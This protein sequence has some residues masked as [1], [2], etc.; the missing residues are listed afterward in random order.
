ML[1][2]SSSFSTVTKIA[3]NLLN[4]LV[5]NCLASSARLFCPGSAEFHIL[6][7]SQKSP[8]SENGEGLGIHLDDFTPCPDKAKQIML[9][10]HEQVFL[11][12]LL[13]IFVLAS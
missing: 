12:K 3:V 4:I 11:D 6:C 10:A 7:L 8:N 2:S 13:D 5:Q 1:F 9:A